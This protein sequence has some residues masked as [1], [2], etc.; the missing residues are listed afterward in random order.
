[1]G[2]ITA[3]AVR[4]DLSRAGFITN[5]EKSVWEPTQTL[6]CLGITWNSVLGT[7]KIVN[8]RITKI[9]CTI[10]QIIDADFMVSAR[11]LGF[12]KSRPAARR[13]T[14]HGPR[15]AAH[16][17]KVRGPRFPRF[18]VSAILPRM[19][20]CASAACDWYKMDDGEFGFVLQFQS[21]RFTD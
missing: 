16:L 18:V 9:L 6:N 14:A 8:R 10:D 17:F 3:Q 15:P 1:M 12:A 2:H 5:D 13:P 21:I 20:R 11:R 7:L 4:K 19:P